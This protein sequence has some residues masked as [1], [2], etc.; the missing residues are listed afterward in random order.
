VLAPLGYTGTADPRQKWPSIRSNWT[1]QLVRPHPLRRLLSTVCTVW[2]ILGAGG[3]GARRVALS[4]C[5]GL[6][7]KTIRK[8]PEPNRC[9]FLYLTRSNSFFR[10]KWILNS[11][12]KYGIHNS[13]FGT[14][15][16]WAFVR[17]ISTLN[18]VLN[19]I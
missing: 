5:P 9:R 1:G 3:S 4:A 8:Y 6:G 18:S 15:S 11:K 16:V 19:R 14:K 13:E 7:M 2:P 17:S 12:T 10:Q